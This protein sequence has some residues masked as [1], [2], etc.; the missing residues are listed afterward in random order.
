[1][2]TP[3][4][5]KI[6]VSRELTTPD[7]V[8]SKETGLPYKGEFIYN[9]STKQY[10]DLTGA[11]ELERAVD[12]SVDEDEVS[13]TKNQYDTLIKQDEVYQLRLTKSPSSYTPSPTQQDKQE[14]SILRYF[15]QNKQTGEVQEV[16]SLT[17][18]ELSSKST[19]YHHPS[20]LIGKTAWLLGGPVANQ[21]VNGYIVR[22]TAEKNEELISILESTL[23]NIRT[24]LTDPT[25]FVE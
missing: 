25:Q 17:Y 7:E 11:I 18:T 13:I 22:G 9:T 23:P 19:T 16:S 5:K 3:K 14:G 8:V 24:Y 12:T 21:D 1:M 6:K 2:Y 10:T 15:V 4:G 20:Y